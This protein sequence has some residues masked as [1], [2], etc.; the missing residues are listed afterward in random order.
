MK[1]SKLYGGIAAGFGMILL[2][3][4]SKTAL[5]GAR[6]GIDLCIRTVIPSLFPFF[7]LSSVLNRALMGTSLKWLRPVGALCGLPEGAEP[8]LIPAFLGGYP[9]GAQSVTAAWKAGQLS[10]Q[11]AQ[12]MLAFCSNAGPS[13]LFG[14]V[15]A[16]FPEGKIPWLLW[17]I[18]IAGALLTAVMLPGRSA[19]RVTL[20]DGH[21][22]DLTDTLRG[23]IFVMACVCG[24]VV[25]FRILIVFLDRWVLWLLPMNLRVAVVGVLELSNGCCDLWRIP[26]LRVRIM[27]ASLMLSCGGLCVLMQ[28]RSVTQGLSL[29]YYLLGKLIQTAVCMLL[30]D[31]LL[32][33]R[34]LYAPILAFFALILRKTENRAG[35]PADS[36]V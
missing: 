29:R 19:D 16:M 23:S 3:L 13:F 35:I 6:E 32:Y 1:N 34:W 33:R 30:W 22:E 9:V 10:R 11:D 27:L 20:N 21:R 36:G 17:L 31:M 28:T 25:L 15:A 2:I 12:R 4:D 24:W 7:V 14:M 26:D 8:I 5:A 18:H